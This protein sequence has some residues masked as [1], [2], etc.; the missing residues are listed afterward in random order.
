MDVGP[1]PRQR[2]L[3]SDE[4]WLCN[5]VLGIWPVREL[6]GRAFGSTSTAQRLQHWLEQQ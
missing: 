6:G 1:L 3:Q 5:A 4:A 2:L